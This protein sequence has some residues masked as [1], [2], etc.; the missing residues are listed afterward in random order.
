MVKANKHQAKIYASI[1]L[2][3][4]LGLWWLVTSFGWIKDFFLPSPLQVLIAA[5]DLFVINNFSK[6]IGISIFRIL[7]G[8]LVAILAGLPVGFFLGLN[9]R[10]S[11]S[12]EPVIDFIRYTP[13]PAFIPLFILWLGIGELE[14]IVVIA[15]SVFFQFA[16][17]VA[18]SVSS[19]PLKLIKSGK[20]LGANRWQIII[21]VIFPFAKPRIFDDLR[22][23]MG[24]AW[25]G[26][27]LAEL[28]GSTS[29]IGFVIIQSQR[30]LQTANVIAAIIIVG[31]L[32]LLTD[33]IFNKLYI[34]Y[35]PWAPKTDHHA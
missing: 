11:L 34:K 8:F 25:S 22:I 20:T 28:V 19:V 6:D 2:L 7:I 13:I 24:W 1:T 35:F 29:G 12:V 14:K 16:L 3:I 15:V 32:G 33:F 5:K 9:K 17:M 23:S 21:K 31:M 18:N 27:M 4:L 10:F 30:L 26:L